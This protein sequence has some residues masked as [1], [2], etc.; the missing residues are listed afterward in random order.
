MPLILPFC[1]H[2]DFSYAPS[3]ALLDDYLRVMLTLHHWTGRVPAVSGWRARSVK[4]KK[5]A[6][7]QRAY[8]PFLPIQ[9]LSEA[10]PCPGCSHSDDLQLALK[11]WAVTCAALGQG[12]QTVLLADSLCL[13]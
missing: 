12:D 2:L 13:S 4:V 9:C 1:V 6:P 7:V 11:E 10:N 3:S 5:V 8:V